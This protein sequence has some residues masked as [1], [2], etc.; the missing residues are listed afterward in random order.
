LNADQSRP[1]FLRPSLNYHFTR[2]WLAV[3]DIF[4]AS[5][6]QFLPHKDLHLR[7]IAQLVPTTVIVKEARG[8]SQLTPLTEALSS[9]KPFAQDAVSRLLQ[10]LE[11]SSEI[12][13]DELWIQ[14]LEE[15]ST[16]PDKSFIGLLS[17]HA[18][19]ILER[20]L[21]SEKGNQLVV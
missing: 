11:A 9:S 13:R 7:L 17:W 21:S 12:N 8:I 1:F 15:V 6:W 4:W 19:D 18:S 3:P 2:L 14:F 16:H 10:A 20:Q 5:F